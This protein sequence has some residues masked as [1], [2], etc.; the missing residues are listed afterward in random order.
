MNMSVH[1]FRVRADRVVSERVLGF[2]L[3]LLI[4]IPGQLTAADLSPVPTDDWQY[5]ELDWLLLNPPVDE[6]FQLTSRPYLR[7]DVRQLIDHSYAGSNAAIEWRRKKLVD[8]YL[9]RYILTSR[10][11]PTLEIRSKITPYSTISY[12]DSLKPLYRVGFKDEVAIMPSEN[13]TIYVRGRLENKG[14]RDSFFKGRIW[15]KKLTGYF[16]YGVLALRHGGFTLQYGRS[17]RLWGAGDRGR[18][19]LSDNSPAFDQ[20]YGEYRYKRFMFQAFVTRLTD[21]LSAT[22]GTIGRYLAGHR[23]SFKPRRNLE[24][25]LSETVLYGRTTGLDWAYMNPFF[26]YYWEQYNIKQNDNVYMGADFV[27]WPFAGTRLYGELLIDDFQIDFSSEPQQVGFDLGLSRLG[28]L[29]ASR[30]RIDAQYTQIRKWVYGQA[31]PDNAFTNNGV[32]IGSSLGPDADRTR[33]SATYALTEDLTFSVGGSLRRKGEGRVTD[34]QSG[35]VPKGEPFPSGTVE[36]ASSEFLR[37]GYLRG[38]SVDLG[39]EAGFYR[40]LNP[41][42]VLGRIDSP[43]IDINIQYYLQRWLLL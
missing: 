42:N 28:V 12:S 39:V 10:N 21:Y 37:I 11:N 26:P 24:I 29:G 41:G 7:T 23:I 3:I 20:L 31:K 8:E 38:T 25:G 15:K 34:P 6:S 9:H 13:L 4:L 17:F 19:L 40:V 36:E 30:L 5:R 22:E 18:L 2:F 43:Y 27:W 33:I 35:R 14:Y 32:V 1:S 16:D